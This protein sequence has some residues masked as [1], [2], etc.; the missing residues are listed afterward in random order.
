ME[1]EQ[2][3]MPKGLKKYETTL[4]E[5]SKSEPES[6]EISYMT[7]S[8]VK[9]IH[10]DHVV[11][12]YVREF[13]LSKIPAFNDALLEQSGEYYFMEFKSGSLRDRKK[14]SEVKRKIYES[15]LIF[16]DICKTTIS[17]SRQHMTYVLVYEPE[18]NQQAL[19]GIMN[20]VGNL[21]KR[22]ADIFGLQGQFKNVYFKEVHVLSG[23]ELDHNFV[24]KHF[25][26][27]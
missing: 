14:M 6:G 17:F 11:H 26:E 2:V 18:K 4:K 3:V 19:T 23:A 12:D 25:A 22:P 5:T 15:L 9:A 16:C 21:A 20:A 13:H 1:I 7:E 27:E 10:F 8:Q 24:P